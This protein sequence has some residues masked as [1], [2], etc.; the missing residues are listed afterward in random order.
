MRVFRLAI[1]IVLIAVAAHAQSAHRRR[2]VGWPFPL[3]P[4]AAGAV[5]SAPD[6]ED[7]ALSGAYVYFGDDSGTVWRVP[8]DGGVAPTQLARIAGS[9]VIWVAA[10][11][12]SVYFSTVIDDDATLTADFYSMPKEG[13]SPA[14]VASGVLTPVA[15]ATDAQFIYWVSLGTSAGED[16]LSDGA[17]R[18]VAKTG[19]AVQTLASGL[20]FPLALA[21]GGGSVFYDETGI[22][23]GNTSAGLRRVPAAGGT[24]VHLFDS[25]PVGALALDDASV[26]FTVFKLGTGLVDIDRVAVGGG[27]PTTL[28]AGLDFAD[29]LIVQGGSLYYE[30]VMNETPS[31]EAISTSGGASRTVVA[32]D[33]KLARLAFDE[34]LIYYATP[35]NAIA[36]S[37]R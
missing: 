32:T 17:V 24:S 30:A 20:S 29:G 36:R 15:F 21:V 18:R 9:L 22:A 4:C 31:I 12:T 8:K 16:I 19:G 34:C 3:A 7:F 2:A 14:V 11:D 35:A 28:V 5:T 33:T 10:D 1:W 6:V 13:G 27:A 23:A 26:Y 37:A 25:A